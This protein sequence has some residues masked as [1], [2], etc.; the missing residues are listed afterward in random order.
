MANLSKEQKKLVDDFETGASA[1]GMSVIVD[2]DFW[3]PDEAGEV[4]EGVIMSIREAAPGAKVQ[5]PIMRVK[6]Q[7]GTVVPVGLSK[8][9][10]SQIPGAAVSVGQRIRIM[11]LGTEPRPGQQSPM[12]LYK[13]A[14]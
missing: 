2:G 6:T 11:F 13:V 5:R 10:E 8:I 7:D 14:M 12:N 4:L 1:D 9:L 3:S